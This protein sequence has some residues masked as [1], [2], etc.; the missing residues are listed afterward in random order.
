ME[1]HPQGGRPEV[2][3]VLLPQNTHHDTKVLVLHQEDQGTFIPTT[4]K[5]VMV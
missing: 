4:N 3:L 2:G 1:K 5:P